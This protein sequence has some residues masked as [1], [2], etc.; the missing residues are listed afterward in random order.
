MARTPSTV[1]LFVLLSLSAGCSKP[2]DDGAPSMS[3]ASL[4]S[5]GEPATAERPPLEPLTYEQERVVEALL[6]RKAACDRFE[7]GFRARSARAFERWRRYRAAEIAAIE[8]RP[9]F[10]AQVAEMDRVAAS[11][12]GADSELGS[13]ALLAIFDD[14]GRQNDP[15]LSSPQAAW[16]EFLDALSRADRARALA[17]LSPA[18]REAQRAN[19]TSIPD[20][21]LRETGGAFTRFDLREGAG[22]SRTGTALR[23]DGTVHPVVFD[24]AWN[25][26]WRITSF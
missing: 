1:L 14:E 22:S 9:G 5:G 25:G 19:L 6:L 23:K 13:D 17:C 4:D 26:D 15:R 10:A 7:P 11:G 16:S 12:G 3:A 18:G 2:A 24:R 20:A 21:T 8:S